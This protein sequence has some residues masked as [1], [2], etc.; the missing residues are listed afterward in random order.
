MI[1]C[2]SSSIRSYRV[3]CTRVYSSKEKT[4]HLV[5]VAKGCSLAVGFSG[6]AIFDDVNTLE[7]VL[8]LG[9]EEAVMYNWIWYLFSSD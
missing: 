8:I 4:L 5:L 1:C 7:L 6:P 3:Q 9:F 2:M